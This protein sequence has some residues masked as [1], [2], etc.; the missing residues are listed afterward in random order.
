MEEQFEGMPELTNGQLQEINKHFTPY[1]F[2]EKYKSKRFDAA[3]VPYA[4]NMYDCVC[5]SCNTSYTHEFDRSPRHNSLEHCP[6]CGEYAQLKHKSYGKKNLWEEQRILVVCPESENR[7]WLRAF[8]AYKT[9]NG[10]PYGNKTLNSL[11]LKTD[12]QLTPTPALSETM[13]Y[14]LEPGK[15]QCW[16]YVYSYYK[17][18]EWEKVNVREPFM[19]YMGNGASYSV[20]SLDRLEATFLKYLDLDKWFDAASAFYEFHPWRVCPAS[21]CYAR[22][23]CNFAKYP[24]IESLMKCDCESIVVKMVMHKQPNKRYFDWDAV[25]LTDFFKT[26]SRKEIKSLHCTVSTVKAYTSFKKAYP[27]ATPELFDCDRQK[28]GDKMPM[29]TQSAAKHRLSYSKAKA[30]LEKQ[31]TKLGLS[32]QL[33]HDYLDMAKRLGYDMK[34]PVI[35]FPK[36]LQRKHDEAAV[37]VAALVKEEECRNMATLTLKLQQKYAFT[38]NGLTI[39]VPQTMQDIVTE[40][41]VLSHCVGG[42]AERHANGKLA[43]LFIRKEDAPDMPYVTMEVQ[44]TRVVQVHGYKNDR[45]APLAKNVLDFV[46][47]FKLYI[48]DPV[49]YMREKERKSA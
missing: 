24:I 1:I 42:Y 44:G 14:L 30:Y 28:Y 47:E 22:Y 16:H 32:V 11:Y 17:P 4:V 41:K 15:A 13:R 36:E 18:H 25:K 8:Y 33:W 20:L 26:L 31:K 38:M 29:L 37:N 19:S 27:K 7:V 48:Q 35:Q 46:K 6:N 9:Y 34:N 21:P 40:G 5:T 45:M 39:V 12:E 23:I 10:D 49:A 43:I 2:Y 3:G